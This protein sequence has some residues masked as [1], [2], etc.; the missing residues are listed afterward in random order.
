M[1]KNAVP[2]KGTMLA[3]GSRAFELYHSK[4]PKAKQELDKHLKELDA[5]YAKL[6]K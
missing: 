2:Y 6:T 3:P 4:D 5:N 1:Y